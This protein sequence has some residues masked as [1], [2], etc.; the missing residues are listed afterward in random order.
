MFLGPLT[1]THPHSHPLLGQSPKKN[2]F[3]LSVRYSQIFW[4]LKSS[5]NGQIWPP[6]LC[7]ICFRTFLDVCS[8]NNWMCVF[9]KNF[10]TF[11]PHLPIVYDKVLKITVCFFGQLPKMIIALVFTVGNIPNEQNT[12]ILPKWHKS[13]R[14]S[15]GRGQ[16][17]E[18]FW[19]ICIKEGAN[20][21]LHNDLYTA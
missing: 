21:T 8:T 20:A 14:N 18:I 7:I 3:F 4:G 1:P 13:C 16:T 15:F 19:D 17:M 10:Q 11:D 12:N 5:W 9:T 2:A 6:H